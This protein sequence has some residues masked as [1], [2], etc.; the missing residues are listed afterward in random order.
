MR[1]H[2]WWVP[3][4]GVGAVVLLIIGFVVSGEPPDLSDSSAREIADFYKD[5]K[6]ALFVGAALQAVSLTFLL[7]FAA[8]LSRMIR[9][10]EGDG[11]LLSR[12][13]FA[14]AVIFAAGGAFDATLTFTMAETADDISPASLQTLSALF[15]NDFVPL[16]LG[17]QVFLL[18]VGLAAIRLGTLPKWLGWVAVLVAVL[19]ITPIGFVSFM[20]LG[21][22]ILVVSVLLTVRG[23]RTGAEPAA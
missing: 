19:A 6:D 21:L 9:A 23:R 22:W 1:S 12:V 10:L 17:I 16:A 7:F 15:S 4:T 18:S 14:G 8:H 20:A 11:G 3:L 13:A 5:N 2:G